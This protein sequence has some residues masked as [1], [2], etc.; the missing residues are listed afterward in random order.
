MNYLFINENLT[1]R[2]KHLFWQAKQKV[3]EL[4]YE[5]IRKNNGQ[6]FVRKNENED[7]II[8]KTKNNL[9]KIKPLNQS[10]QVTH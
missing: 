5:F 1:H 6:F 2:R 8:V 4:N 10:Q 9:N 7:K 3:K